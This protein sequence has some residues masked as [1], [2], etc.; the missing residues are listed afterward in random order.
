MYLDVI[1]FTGVS[2]ALRFPRNIIPCFPHVKMLSLR[3]RR[4]RRVEPPRAPSRLFR[5]AP[6]DLAENDRQVE[7]AQTVRAPTGPRDPWDGLEP[8]GTKHRALT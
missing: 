2:A 4:N 3:V 6:P 5:L 7:R 8:Q 1:F